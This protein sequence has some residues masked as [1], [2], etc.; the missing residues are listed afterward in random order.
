MEIENFIVEELI[1]FL[2]GLGDYDADIHA[3]TLREQKNVK[4]NNYHYR[5]G[6]KIY[7]DRKCAICDRIMSNPRPDRKTCSVNCRKELSRNRKASQ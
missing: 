2:E 4:A 5:D 6:K 7:K 1:T 3:Q